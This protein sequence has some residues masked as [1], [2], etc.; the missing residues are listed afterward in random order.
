MLIC[1]YCYAYPHTYENTNEE[2][3]KKKKPEFQKAVVVPLVLNFS[4]ELTGERA[5]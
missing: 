2:E 5:I 1:L 3:K 4:S